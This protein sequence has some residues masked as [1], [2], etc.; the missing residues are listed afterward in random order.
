M[1]WPSRGTQGTTAVTAVLRHAARLAL[2]A[3]DAGWA[4]TRIELPGGARVRA[5][6]TRWAARCMPRKLG[7]LAVATVFAAA[8]VALLVFQPEHNPSD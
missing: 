3:D 4:A 8:P 7:G 5:G 2:A 6:P 1:C